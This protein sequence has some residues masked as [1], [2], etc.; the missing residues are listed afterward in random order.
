LSK[1]ASDFPF[2]DLPGRRMKRFLAGTLGVQPADAGGSPFT[3][4][5]LL[6]KSR[7]SQ[8]AHARLL[9]AASPGR[10]ECCYFSTTAWQMGDSPARF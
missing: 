7:G 1:V 9:R 4:I 2:A 3:D 6:D 10:V 5:Q 8:D